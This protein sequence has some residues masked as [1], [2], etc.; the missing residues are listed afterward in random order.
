MEEQAEYGSPGKLIIGT[1]NPGD[2]PRIEKLNKLS[3]DII[4]L[5]HDLDNDD[6]MADA[7]KEHAVMAVLKA[8][9]LCSKYILFR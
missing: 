3:A 7:I 1:D 5:M 6:E 8:H 4:D 9:L 2:N